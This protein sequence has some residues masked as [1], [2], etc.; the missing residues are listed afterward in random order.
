MS[1]DSPWQ[2]GCYKITHHEAYFKEIWCDTHQ[3]VDFTEEIKIQRCHPVV[4]R[5]TRKEI[6]ENQLTVSLATIPGLFVRCS[7]F[8]RA[9]LDNNDG[10]CPATGDS[11]IEYVS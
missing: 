4:I 10:R 7:F 3:Y 8:L 11:C 2:D 5:N 1:E 9:A 6:H